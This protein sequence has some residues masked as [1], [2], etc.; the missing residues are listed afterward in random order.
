MPKLKSQPKK[1]R[2]SKSARPL[3]RKTPKPP[4]TAI[5]RVS[6]APER[7]WE[8]DNEAITILKNSVAKGASDEELKYC[9]TV[10]RRYKLDP[11]KQQIWFVKRWDSSADNGHGGKG[12]YVWTPQV[13]INGL[14]F[15]AAR[16]H[17][18][19]F[20]SV[21]LPEFGPMQT[22]EWTN[23]KGATLSFKAP[24]WAKVKVWK[25]GEAE[26]T[27]AQAWWD[28][29]APF[30]LA[31]APFWRKM[32]RRMIAKCA[33]AL[34]TR[35][36]YP[37]LG[38][39]Y[40]PEEME[41]MSEDYTASGRQIVQVPLGGSHA[42][43]QRVLEDKLAGKRPLS[44]AEPEKPPTAPPK[45]VIPNTPIEVQ[46]EQASKGTVEIDETDE[47]HPIIRGDIA[48]ILPQL[49]ERC[50]T[51]KWVNEWWRIEPRDVEN[52]RAVCVYLGYRV[53]EIL[54]K[55]PPKQPAKSSGPKEAP[56]H[57]TSKSAA[58]PAAK[59]ASSEPTLVIGMIEQA[60]PEPGKSPRVSVLLKIDKVKHWMSAFDTVLFGF[61]ISGKGQEAELFVTKTVKGDKTYT[62]IVGLNRVGSKHFDSDGKT[63]IIQ[64]REREAGGRTLF[65]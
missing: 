43:A 1:V 9:L 40:I 13:G 45:A 5:V 33:T 4:S 34:A 12:A 61:L 16:D 58:V 41:R 6:P 35:Q 53:L 36:A 52:A 37:D 38:G 56:A 65:P 48:E 3:R 10:A 20:G 47:A 44:A 54:P 32:P 15:A 62:N 17:K 25:K 26:P 57:Q 55:E 39:V 50:K 28:E 27:E 30:D 63:P 8:L 22:Q 46:P 31:K 24:E 59:Q 51:M 19:M 64:N 7:P 18:A 21:S 23:D 14:L 49:Q 11:F 60:S 42:A 29:Y 2:A